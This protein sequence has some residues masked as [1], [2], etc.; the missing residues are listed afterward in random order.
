M[1]LSTLASTESL[2]R[3][4]MQFESR[5]P[6]PLR[7]DALWQIQSGAVRTFTWLEDGNLATLGLWGAGD[8]VSHLLS[9]AN[10]YQIECLTPVEAT[11]FPLTDYPQV[12]EALIQHIKKLQQFLE[13]LHTR[14]LDVALV[15]LLGWLAKKFGH[16]VDKGKLID[17]RLT[18]QE[19]A[20]IIGTS[21]VTVTRILNVFE[22]QGI[23]EKLPRQSILLLEESAT[24]YYE[25]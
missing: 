13:I 14:P 9:S 12:N 6:L 5:S 24:W 23:I 8:V 21:R 25:I 15:R 20:E 19:I 4:P 2:N 17:L 10:P 7:R 22:Q 16:E 3:K 11:L 1:T 18:H